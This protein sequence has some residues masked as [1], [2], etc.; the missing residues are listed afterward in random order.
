VVALEL[1][2]VKEMVEESGGGIAVPNDAAAMA[3]AIAALLDDPARADE[4][5]AAGRRAAEERYSWESVVNRT[6]A[7]FGLE[8]PR[9]RA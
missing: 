4:L 5:G 2:G 3:A 7:L 1:P 9:P 6:V 8:T